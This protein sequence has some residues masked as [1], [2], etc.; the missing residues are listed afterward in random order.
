VGPEVDCLAV[1]RDDIMEPPLPEPPLRR[2]GRNWHSAAEQR[3][4]F[5]ILV[6]IV[7]LAAWAERAWLGPTAPP[8]PPPIDTIVGRGPVTRTIEDGITIEAPP[9][10]EAPTGGAAVEEPSAGVPAASETL[11]D[12]ADLALVRDDTVFRSAD[13]RAWFTIWGRL[14]AEAAAGSKPRG[15]QVTFA[16]LFSQPRSFR[17]RRVR[18][19]GTI[20]RLQEV[21]APTNALGIGAYW[22]AWLEP[23]D[24][25]ASPIVVYFLSLPPG[26]PSGMRVEIPAVV[27]G[28]FF[29]RW[30]YQA[31]DAIRLAP[32]L[33]ATEPQSP[34]R[35]TSGRGSTTIVGWALFSIAGLIATTW[36]T[37][38]FA[39]AN[40]LPKQRHPASGVADFSD[41]TVVDQSVS[42][43]RLAAPQPRSE[44]AETPR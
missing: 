20:R 11:A 44:N 26:T 40:P 38:R 33:M 27:D 16:Q 2:R 4:L 3:R 31:S 17:G 14:Q 29:K 36:L 1:M 42:F 23:A 5:W 22:Q 12:P 34:P 37:L 8:P 10:I 18:I 41:L 24:G 25:P 21:T 39:A 15:R 30:A 7:L 13:Q 28:V 35:I 19:A 43:E 9:A 32:L 6:P